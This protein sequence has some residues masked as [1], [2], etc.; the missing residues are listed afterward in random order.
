MAVTE[1]AV[2]LA[3]VAADYTVL[4]LGY[5]DS[6]RDEEER[7]VLVVPVLRRDG[8]LLLA[9][10]AS[11]PPV[12]LRFAGPASGLVAVPFR[13]DEAPSEAAEQRTEVRFVDWGEPEM[14]RGATPEE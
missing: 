7:E 6:E 4:V 8:G 12:A 3:S 11:V 5:G 10:P 2:V 13:L 14:L 9:V 1:D